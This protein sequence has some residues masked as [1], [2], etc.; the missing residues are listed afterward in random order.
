MTIQEKIEQQVKNAAREIYGA[1]LETVEFQATRKEF[2]GDMTIVTFPMLRQIKTNPVEL[3][4]KLGTYL[5]ENISEVEKYNVVK[6]FLNIV[7][8]D[9]YFCDAFESIKNNPSFGNVSINPEEK[10][11]MVEYSSP[12]TNKPLHLGHVRNNLLGYSVAEILKASGRKVYKTQIINDRGIHIC[13]SMLAWQRFGNGE[14][15]ESTGL[16]GDKLVGNYYVKF[17]K[18]YKEEI[19]YLI[20]QGKS[21]EEAKKIAPILLDAQDMLLKWEAGDNEIVSLWNKMN[22]WV[23]DGFEKTYTNLGVDFDKNYYESDTYLLG[24][25]VVADGLAK[26]VFYKKDDG[27]VWID[28]TDEGLDEKI[29]L[30]SDGTA[31]YITQDIG[32]AIQRVKDFDIDSLVYTVGN[33]QDYHFK[34][35]FLILKKLG[36]EWAEHLYHLSYGMVDLPSGKMKSREGTVV[37]ADDLIEE[38]ANTAAKISEELG[39][40]DDYSETEKKEL[41]KV[42]G[43]GA[44]KYYILK[45]DPRKRILF[46]PEES[47]DFQGNTG[48]FIQYTYARIKSILRKADFDFSEEI[49]GINLHSKERELIKQLQ[50]YP[51]M[52]QLAA[53]QFSPAIIANY[54]YD[55]VKSFNSFY[56][57]VSILGADNFTEKVFRVQLAEQVAGTIQSAFGLLGIEVPERM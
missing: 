30:R 2:E 44:L 54:T 46:N 57:N 13:K 18:A 56:Q 12:N 53:A 34:V 19:S 27:S 20:A 39:K 36:Y 6:G 33:E 31:V 43:L 7:L 52:V 11:V 16:K 15:P 9:S 38:M 3:G 4:E 40:L 8:N 42:I 45:V 25:D 5:Q 14:T 21:E 49:N 26:G 29:V 10:A 50:L 37:D 55:L 24:K 23:Y 22:Q 51:E 35:L 48:P 28:L 32:T 41:Y 47:V 1:E 17:D